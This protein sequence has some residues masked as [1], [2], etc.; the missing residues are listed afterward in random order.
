[1]YKTQSSWATAMPGRCGGRSPAFPKEVPSSGL[2][3]HT[4]AGRGPKPFGRI[5]ARCQNQ[6]REC[7]DNMAGNPSLAHDR[8][9]QR[10]GSSGRPYGCRPRPASQKRDAPPGSDIRREAHG[11]IEGG[12]YPKSHGISCVENEEA[13]ASEKREFLRGRPEWEYHSLPICHWPM[14]SSP[15]ELASMLEHISNSERPG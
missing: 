14:L 8:P 11:P 2:P 3:R 13:A 4:A 1:M 6:V 12:P 10:S 7:P 5:P 15:Q 9:P